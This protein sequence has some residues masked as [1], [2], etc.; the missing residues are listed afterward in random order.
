MV[1]KCMSRQNLQSLT[2]LLQHAVNVIRPGRP[3]L[4]RLYALQQVVTRPSHH[5][6]LNAAAWGDIMWWHIFVNKWKGISLAWDLGCHSPEITV[7]SD[8]SGSWGCGGYTTTDW[9]QYKWLAHHQDLSIASK[10]LI[11]VVISAAIFGRCWS[12]KLVNFMVDNLAVVQ[13]L[14]ATYS[15][16]IHLMHLIRLLVLFAAH[17]NFWFTASHVAGKKNTCDAISRNDTEILQQLPV[18][19]VQSITW[20]CTSWIQPLDSIF[21][22]L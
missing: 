11:P 20:T 10:E 19:L 1:K 13:A 15:R 2:G 3:F 5:I 21:R 17:F 7:Y 4:H 12:G 8:A 14:Q 9:F 18:L 22:Q 16:D 6:R